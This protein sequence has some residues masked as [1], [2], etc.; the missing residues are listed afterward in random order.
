MLRL[1][2]LPTAVLLALPLLAACLGG[3][4]TGDPCQ[5]YCDYICDCHAGEAEYDCDSCRTSME[6]SDPALQDE[7]E[8]ELVAL[9]DADQD[10]GTGC[11][12]DEPL[13]TAR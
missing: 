3:G 12:S 13:D 10:A 11:F 5:D 8:T 4:A 2:R 6:S 7:C 9:Q 1:S